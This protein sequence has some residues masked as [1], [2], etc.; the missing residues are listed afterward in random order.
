MAEIRADLLTS[1]SQRGKGSPLAAELD[2]KLAS[3][4]PLTS[5]V[6]WWRDGY[7]AWV[8]SSSPDGIRPDTGD[9]TENEQSALY[10][11]SAWELTPGPGPLTEDDA[12]PNV[13]LG[14]NRVRQARNTLRAA[15]GGQ[16]QA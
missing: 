12:D 16:A 13:Q 2:R 15:A 8:K 7:V 4:E 1:T 10:L 14:W 6:E 5:I 9:L 3:T 11:V